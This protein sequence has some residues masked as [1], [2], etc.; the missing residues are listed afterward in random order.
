MHIDIEAQTA[1]LG[2]DHLQH[3]RLAVEFAR[4]NF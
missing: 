2:W 1:N 3:T 4:W